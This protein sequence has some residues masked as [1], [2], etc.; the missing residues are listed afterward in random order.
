M[1]PTSDDGSLTVLAALPQAQL[2]FGFSRGVTPDK[3]CKS[4]EISPLDLV[5]RERAVP[6]AW[7][8]ALWGALKEHCGGVAVGTEFGTFLSIEHLG[9]AGQLFRHSRDGLEVLDKAARF[10][11]LV[12]SKTARCPSR[13]E[14]STDEVR[15]VIPHALTDLPECL[16]ATTFGG[17][18]QLRTLLNAPIRL[19]AAN[20]HL[21][22][23]ELRET[24][25]A[26][27]GCSV[28]FDAPDTQLVFSRAELERPIAGSDPDKAQSIEQY[29]TDT[30]LGAEPSARADA[31]GRVIDDLL[32]RGGLSEEATARALGTS[33]R[34]LQRTLN[35]LG[36]SYQELSDA[37]RRA[38]ALRLLGEPG[39]AVYEVALALGYH[40]ASSFNR[41]FKRWTG[42][43][44]RDYRTS[45]R[46]RN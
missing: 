33:V 12:N 13:V 21:P 38:A 45:Q 16:D 14:L 2:L 1:A 26:F 3:L 9:Y 4:A 36:T 46:A 27:L 43:A 32:N 39:L 34:S 42:Q 15:L 7:Y 41:A 8:R 40:D 20:L 31:V 25:E 28:S 23:H 29:V 44:P 37:R 19:R 18:S 10:G 30:L 35:G 22:R 5:D 6:Y 24:Y 17:V 11:C